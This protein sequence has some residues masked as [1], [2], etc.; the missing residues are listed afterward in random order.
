MST[1][2]TRDTK[3]LERIA[4]E[5]RA[6]VMDM[7]AA[8]GSGH[9]AG[10]LGMAEMMTALYFHCLNHDPANPEWAERDVLMP[11]SYTHLDVYKRQAVGP[12]RA[13]GAATHPLGVMRQLSNAVSYTH[14]D[15]YKRQ[16]MAG[17]GSR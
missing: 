10:P 14:L 6:S 1:Q 15:V 17:A 12:G 4:D 16:S 11:V 9:S 7:L 8:A 13:A 2:T 5:L 3:D